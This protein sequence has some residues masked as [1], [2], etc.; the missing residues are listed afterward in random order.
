[1]N[2]T[3]REAHDRRDGRWKVTGT[4][5]YT[6]DLNASG[7]LHA[8]LVLSTVAVGRIRH[9][10][11]AAAAVTPGF[12]TTI[13]H[14]NSTKVARGEFLTWLQDAEIHHAG[15][16]VAMVV[17][18]SAQAAR[19]AAARVVVSYETRL[20]RSR[21]SAELVSAELESADLDDAFEPHTVLG[22]P[23]RSMRGDL[24]RGRRAAAA[25]VEAIYT[26][27]GHNHCPMEPHAVHAA[28]DGDHVT[29]H[30]STSGIFAAR[31]VVAKALQIPQENVRVLMHY[32]GGG[33]G[34]KGSA[35][36]PTLI[37]AV[38]AARKLERPMFLQLTREQMF[39]VAGRRSPTVQRIALGATADGRLTFIDHDAVQETSLIDYSD[40][41][42]FATRS[43]YS[44]SN[45]RTRHRVK[46][47]NAPQPNAMR[48]PGEGPGS[49]ALECA[50][51]ELACRLQIDPL[52]LRLRNIAARDEHRDRSWSSNGLRTCL[53]EGA[54]AFEWHTRAGTHAR[55][56]DHWLI[57]YG[58]ACAYYPA[59]QDAAFARVRIDRGGKVTLMCGN[60]DIGTGSLT[61]MAQAIARELGVPAADVHVE[62][63]DTNL[64]ATPMAA[65]S[66]SSASVIP[67]IERAA[68]ALR[69]QLLLA[70]STD[71]RSPFF[72]RDVETLR[73][74]SPQEIRTADG[75]LETTAADLLMLFTRQSWEASA[76]AAPAS[77]PAR[78]R[79]AFGALFCEVGVDPSIGLVR[80][81]RI[82]AAYAAGRI[83]NPKM[84][85][86]Q[87]I[88]GIVFGI[89]MALHECI[90][91]DVA[92]GLVLNH[93]LSGYLIPS[94][95]DVPDIDVRLVPETDDDASSHGIKGVGMIGTVGVAAAIA[96]AVF[97]ATR[98]RVRD[99][100]IT[101]DKV[102]A[103]VKQS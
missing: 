1:M 33:F 55:R 64:P 20:P 25:Q 18:E 56:D 46:R 98:R 74:I 48:A 17:A 92:T 37:L 78:S 15:Q 32:Q 26:T 93:Q 73:W 103:R 66:M 57:G 63:G 7:A 69:A 90:H 77:T 41:T 87:C 97:D 58:M 38:A 53:I 4:A 23:S 16:P 45:V 82:T 10:D 24:A 59:F 61:I 21:L 47:V 80:V 68:A 5:R 71:P 40:P 76:E 88:G 70:A 96:N 94:H 100:P 95:A 72:G 27:P 85:S 3:R 81:R 9:I 101:V 60:Q 84:A 52:E 39:S 54:R 50:L 31:R 91:D 29:I 14:E 12:V 86:S 44:C 75:A 65:G 67:A 19:H 89:G 83:L 79:S 35:W 42:C 51:D 2:I 6:A 43:T 8:T 36:W 99:L 34:A 30:T 28:W 62:Y 102:L 22:E 13:T 11:Y 49:F